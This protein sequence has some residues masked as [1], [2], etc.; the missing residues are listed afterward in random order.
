MWGPALSCLP[1]FS[2][3]GCKNG[4][5]LKAFDFCTDLPPA[6]GGRGCGTER[7]G[8]A[9]QCRAGPS[10]G[11]PYWCWWPRALH[12]VVLLFQ[13]SDRGDLGVRGPCRMQG[14]S[15]LERWAPAGRFLHAELC[16]FGVRGFRVW[17]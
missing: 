14:V 5:Q 11:G 3:A 9:H 6:E 8:G 7:P 1:N 17:L 15:T 4:S 16:D 13:G 2:V 10:P 12:L